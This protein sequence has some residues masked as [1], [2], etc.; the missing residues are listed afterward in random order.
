MDLGGQRDRD[1]E[2]LSRLGYAQQLLR[3]LGGFSN[4]ALSFSVVSV[5]T[6][7]V[8]LYKHGLEY[9]G[10]ATM[11]LGWPLVSAGTMLVALSMA[12]L[13]SAFPT[14]GSLYHWAMFL[15]DARY[16]FATA[17]F[18]LVGQF[19]IT[20]GIDYGCAE[21][22][23]AFL[24]TPPAAVA[25]VYALLLL[26]HALLNHFGVRLVSRLNDLSAWLHV[27]GVAVLV[28][29]L[30]AFGRAQPLSYAF[31]FDT[32][33]EGGPRPGLFLVALLQG[34]WTFTGY[35]ASAHVAEETRDPARKAPQGILMAVIVSIVVGYLLVV[36]LAL[37][38]KDYRLA[39]NDPT[40][41]L[42]IVRQAFG[43]GIGRAVMSLAIAAMWF[44]GLA[45]VTANSRMI[46]AFARDDGL[47]FSAAL[48]KV[49]PR[50]RTPAL[51]IWVATGVA[52]VLALAAKL[53]SD[54][55]YTVVTSLSTVALYL[56][57]GVPIFLGAVA[58]HTGRWNRFGPF[59]LGRAGKWVGLAATLWLA[60]A[61]VLC[62]LPP[63]AMTGLAM[64]GVVAVVTA[65]ALRR[66]K[67]LAG[68]PVVVTR[69][70]PQ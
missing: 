69:L 13:A 60:F 23:V 5:L 55:A 54:S 48:K 21:F 14:A 16:G 46:Y 50:F 62:G 33:H 32:T 27:I 34:F 26:S 64:L 24:D 28:V 44:C 47:P 67:I 29:A 36:G 9:G 45:S 42:Y 37:A 19:A 66:P 31:H 51:A 57:Y 3:D 38:M 11:G 39:A 53:A 40:P 7:A 2:E 56:S 70:E 22:I 8:T 10:P 12:E 1:A 15:G 65:L 49:S 4:F 17:W 52:L 43:D 18:N 35:D 58:R 59:T 6:G 25:P 30:F 63:N 68:L 20:A 61:A 41:P